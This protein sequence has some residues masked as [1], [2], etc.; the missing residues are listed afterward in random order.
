[1][2]L[3]G[4]R[5]LLTGATGGIG[6]ALALALAGAGA[7]LLLT[8]RSADRLALLRDRVA[9]LGCEAQTV[10]ADLATVAGRDAVSASA[11]AFGVDTLINNAGCN[12]FGLY[13]GQQA[14]DIESLLSCN[15]VAPLL[16]TRALL[17]MLGHQ[18]DACIVNVGS[19]LGSIATP[20]Q[21]A[22]S[23][24]KFALRG[25]SE[26]LRREVEADGISVL[27]VAPRATDTAMND[28]EARAI[29]RRLGVT[30]DSADAVAA[31]ILDAM[32]SRSRERYIGW[33]EKMFVRINALFPGLVDRAL[34]KQ[35]L[36]LTEND[37]PADTL[38]LSNGVKQ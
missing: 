15:L 24:S 37:A 31:E 12:R 5:V 18:P 2:M 10:P 25:F 14:Q 3:A 27:Y 30:M 8:G 33:P 17:P 1:M 34:A 32:A 6:E 29:N 11:A 13:A 21:A 19:I 35:R 36:V 23:A 16:L 9:A 7:R 38:A 26:A 4:R 22:Y 20:G 28:A